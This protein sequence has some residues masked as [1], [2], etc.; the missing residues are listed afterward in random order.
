MSWRNLNDFFSFFG[1]YEGNKAFTESYW[2]EDLQKWSWNVLND[3]ISYSGQIFKQN[4]LSKWP[5]L[6]KDKIPAFLG[7][8]YIIVQLFKVKK[9]MFFQSA[10]QK[11]FSSPFESRSVLE[12]RIFIHNQSQDCRERRKRKYPFAHF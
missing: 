10:V 2:R 3:F 12:F 11:L 1:A 4:P 7:E 8:K 6:S 9:D 5:R